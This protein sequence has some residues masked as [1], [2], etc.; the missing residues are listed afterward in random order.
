MMGHFPVCL[1]A[2]VDCFRLGDDWPGAVPEQRRQLDVAGSDNRACTSRMFSTAKPDYKQ[3]RLCGTVTKL[4]NSHLHPKFYWEWRR[5]TGGKYFR[6]SDQPNLRFQDGY[7]LPMLCPACEGQ[8]SKAETVFASEMFRP[9]VADSSAAVTYSGDS[10]YCLISIL[11]R[12]LA[13]HIDVAQIPVSKHAELSDAEIAW[14]SFLLNGSPLEQ[15]QKVHLFITDFPVNDSPQINQYLT[16]D[17]DATAI[18]T[19][20]KLLAYYTKFG[21][22]VVVAEMSGFDRSKWVHTLLCKEGGEFVPGQTR[23]LDGAFR[24]FL[25]DRAGKHRRSRREFYAGLSKRQR[26]AIHRDQERQG[27][28]FQNSDLQRAQVLDSVWD[29]A[30]EK[31]GRNDLCPCGSGIKYKRCHGYLA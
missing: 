14:R 28:A 8:F 19:E 13:Y 26:E 20:A 25:L 30:L 16:R 9:L 24:E 15:F 11:W 18:W 12:C 17:V 29:H 5:R 10:Y 4:C 3:C 31:V 23:I 21:R 1:C 6:V 27:T 2:K 22:F 7:K